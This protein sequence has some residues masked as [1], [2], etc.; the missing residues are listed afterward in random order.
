[1]QQQE[2]SYLAATKET[3]EDN[4]KSEQVLE[5]EKRVMKLEQRGKESKFLFALTFIVLFDCIALE[6]CKNWAAPIGVLFFEIIFII[7]FANR[8]EVKEVKPLIDRLL[9]CFDKRNNNS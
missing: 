9:D 6:D 7:M 1:M 8:C 4:P 2:N 5:L 3:G